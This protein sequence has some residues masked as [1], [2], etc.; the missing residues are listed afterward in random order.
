VVLNTTPIWIS[1]YVK[2]L[3]DA[4]KLLAQATERLSLGARDYFKVIKVA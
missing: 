2:L 4:K 1:E 3:P